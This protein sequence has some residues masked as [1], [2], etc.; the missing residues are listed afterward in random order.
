M[1]AGD[2]LATTCGVQNSWFRASDQWLMAGGDDRARRSCSMNVQS[3]RRCQGRRPARSWVGGVCIHACGRHVSFPSDRRGVTAAAYI[4]AGV[5]PSNSRPHPAAN[6]CHRKK[7]FA[8]K[9]GDVP[10]GMPG[11]LMTCQRSCSARS[12]IRRRRH[13][14]ANPRLRRQLFFPPPDRTPGTPGRAATPVTRHRLDMIGVMMGDQ[15][16]V[17]SQ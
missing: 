2:A 6:R 10:A 13:Q 14:P 3:T 1:R 8:A 11:M 17:Q 15:D 16:C 5:Y 12:A 7:A 4:C 9:V